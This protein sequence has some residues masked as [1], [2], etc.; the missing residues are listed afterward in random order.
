MRNLK[1]KF[2]KD[3]NT[4]KDGRD[5]NRAVSTVQTAE[6]LIYERPGRTATYPPTM[7]SQKEG[8]FTSIVREM[9]KK[10]RMTQEELAQQMGVSVSSIRNWEA[11]RTFPR[12]DKYTKLAM[13]L[14]CEWQEIIDNIAEG[15]VNT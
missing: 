12:R 5:R 9:R 11:K 3:N 8:E 10:K 7:A 6:T 14:E 1:R 4:D 15:L 2:L 13:I